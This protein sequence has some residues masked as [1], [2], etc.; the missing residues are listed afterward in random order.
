MGGH[1]RAWGLEKGVVLEDAHEAHEGLGVEEQREEAVGRPEERREGRV[2]REREGW[3]GVVRLPPPN[4]GVGG[5]WSGVTP[6]PGSFF[7]SQKKP[8]GRKGRGVV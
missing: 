7:G 4:C 8:G 6:P 1:T 2:L 5:P 3:E